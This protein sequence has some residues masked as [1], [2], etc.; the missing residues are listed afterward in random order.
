MKLSDKIVPQSIVDLYNHY[1][2][3]YTADQVRKKW[4]LAGK[5]LPVPHIIKQQTIRYYQQKTGY[6]V[7]VETG[8]YKGDMVLAQLDSFDMIY[9]IEL[10]PTLHERASN[11]FGKNS[12]VR[13]IQGNSGEKLK[14]ILQQLESPAICWIDDHYTGSADITEGQPQVLE[15]QLQ[16]LKD[17]GSK[18]PVILLDDAH[19]F[20]IQRGYPSVEELRDWCHNNFPGY[21]FSVDEDIVRIVPA[22]FT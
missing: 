16:A 2:N 6:H 3:L 17:Q 21:H 22:I 18:Q 1:K 9:S 4:E 15:W 7:L 14:G 10:N 20:N 8:T 19:G 13:L 12:R 5:P 11:R